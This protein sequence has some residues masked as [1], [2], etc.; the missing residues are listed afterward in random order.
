VKSQ[1]LKNNSTVEDLKV[2]FFALVGALFG[3]NF[4]WIP[5]DGLGETI[6]VAIVSTIIGYLGNKLLTAT[7]TYFSSH[8]K[9][10]KEKKS[11][12]KAS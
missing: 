8:I 9:R 5:V 4:K 10:Y 11:N 12:K 6:V 2:G 7:D 3:I 1:S